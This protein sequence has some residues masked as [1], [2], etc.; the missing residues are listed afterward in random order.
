MIY[1]AGIPDS[2]GSALEGAAQPAPQN[3]S[4]QYVCRS[5]A[6]LFE[7]SNHLYVGLYASF[8]SRGK[9]GL[10]NT[11]DACEEVLRSQHG[12]QGA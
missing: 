9:T 1:V 8:V 3:V 11:A 6:L 12:D 5:I 4:A 7:Q 10:V 2:R